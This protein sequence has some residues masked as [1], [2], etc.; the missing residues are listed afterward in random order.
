MSKC[1]ARMEECLRTCLKESIGVSKITYVHNR[2]LVDL[3][4]NVLNLRGPT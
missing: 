1:L 3:I 4:L 2:T